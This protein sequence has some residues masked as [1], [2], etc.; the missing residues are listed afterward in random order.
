MYVIYVDEWR[1]D[2]KMKSCMHAGV[3]ANTNARKKIFITLIGTELF[4][5]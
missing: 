1:I 3:L 4:M 2:L 5:N